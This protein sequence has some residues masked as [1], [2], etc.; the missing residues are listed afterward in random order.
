MFGSKNTKGTTVVAREAN[1]EG[2]LE[3][4]GSAHIEGGF[5]G[6]LRAGTELSVGPEGAVEGALTAD[7]MVIAG[8]VHGTVVALRHLHI[9]SGGRVDGRV[10]YQALQIDRGGALTGE[11]HQGDPNEIEQAGSDADHDEQS[12]VSPAAPRLVAQPAEGPYEVAGRR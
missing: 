2:S 8:R 6:T 10:Y 11:V 4:T 7:T 3:L 9:L 1:F 12:G 5:K